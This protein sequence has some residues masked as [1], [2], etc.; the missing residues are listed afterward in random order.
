MSA[1]SDRASEPRERRDEHDE[2]RE[3]ARVARSG[4]L[5]Q[6]A[7]D[8]DA[9]DNLAT[10]LFLAENSPVGRNA[11]VAVAQGWLDYHRE[12]GPP[13]ASRFADEHSLHIQRHFQ[14]ICLLYGSDPA[15]EA[16]V[17]DE[18][19]LEAERREGGFDAVFDGIAE[20]G[21]SRA[22]RAVAQNGHLSAFGVSDG[23]QRNVSILRIGFWFAKLWWWNTYLKGP[24]K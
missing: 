18:A 20:R 13:D 11:L 2:G 22:W 3:H 12:D 6:R 1:L 15:G 8:R 23:I 4:F 14:V 7:P 21:F 9:A 19:G 17:A 5:L 10:L 24:A 16:A